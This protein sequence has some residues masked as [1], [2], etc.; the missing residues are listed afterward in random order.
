MKTP[1]VLALIVCNVLSN[2]INIFSEQLYLSND[3]RDKI[4]QQYKTRLPNALA[5]P[6]KSML[7]ST[8]LSAA[9]GETVYVDGRDLVKG[10]KTIMALTDKTTWSEVCKKLNL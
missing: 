6:E 2:D 10:Y 1:T 4:R 5:G 7:S 9:S 3:K 8:I